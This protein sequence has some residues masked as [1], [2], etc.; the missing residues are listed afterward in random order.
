MRY[1]SLHKKVYIF[2]FTLIHNFIVLLLLL[3]QEEDT[4]K[5][6][7]RKKSKKWNLEK[8]NEESRKEV[9]IDR[10]LQGKENNEHMA[11]NEV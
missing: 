9:F 3:L 8:N 5:G 11:N 2:L 1:K 6:Q 10:E 7:K 4:Y